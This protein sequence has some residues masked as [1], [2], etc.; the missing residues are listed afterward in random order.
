MYL[1]LINVSLLNNVFIFNTEP[2]L[3]LYCSHLTY[4]VPVS[5]L[6]SKNHVFSIHPRVSHSNTHQSICVFLSG[7]FSGCVCFVRLRWAAHT[8]H[9]CWHCTLGLRLQRREKERQHVWLP[10]LYTSALCARLQG[11][12]GLMQSTAHETTLAVSHLVQGPRGI[13]ISAWNCDR[14]LFCNTSFGV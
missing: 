14:V 9:V 11:W 3:L 13:S 10:G 5:L 6:V 12:N 7:S 2:K 8:P 4:I 1:L